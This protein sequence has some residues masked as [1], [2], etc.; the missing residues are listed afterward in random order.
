MWLGMIKA[1]I[2]PN[3]AEVQ[4]LYTECDEIVRILFAILRKARSTR[5]A[6]KPG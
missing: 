3:V 6:L 4:E 1:A 5:A 2:L